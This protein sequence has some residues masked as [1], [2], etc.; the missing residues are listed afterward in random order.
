MAPPGP[1]SAE[2]DVKLLFV[3]DKPP[4]SSRY[5]APPGPAAVFWVKTTSDSVSTPRLVHATAPIGYWQP[6]KLIAPPL[7]LKLP[8]TP[9]AIV[10]ALPYR[11]VTP[12]SVKFSPSADGL[13]YTFST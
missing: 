10:G 2:F 8:S 3:T 12:V 11:R 5:T 7:S 13:P 1:F 6:L 4:A 9:V